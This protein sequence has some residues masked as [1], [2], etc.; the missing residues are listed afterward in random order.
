MVETYTPDNLFDFSIVTTS[1][2]V[3][4][5][6]D[7]YFSKIGLNGNIPLC[8]QTPKCLTKNGIIKNGKKMYCDL[9]YDKNSD[10]FIEWIENLEARCY[11]LISENS[12]K[13]FQSKLNISDVEKS[14]TSITSTYKSGKFKVVRALVK[15]E[16]EFRMFDDS[17]TSMDVHDITSDIIIIPVLEI[18]G[19][20]FTSKQFHVEIELKQVMILNKS[21]NNYTS[22]CLIDKNKINSYNILN[23]KEHLEEPKTPNAI[24]QIINE[25]EEPLPNNEHLLVISNLDFP[26]GVEIE[27][28]DNIK[29]IVDFVF[30][31]NEEPMVLKK[32]M[33]IYYGVYKEAR[34]KAKIAKRDAHLALIEAKNI[35]KAYMLDN[36]NTSD[37]EF[38][39]EIDNVLDIDNI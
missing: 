27:K 1:I 15:N 26:E 3:K 17:E 32:P 21:Y 22:K 37:D 34:K 14:F 25:K 13:W 7:T 19:I 29:E 2:P 23:I 11:Q 6:G 9:I 20:K 31:N 36:V 10:D 24:A 38:D 35:K 18:S 33:S 8:I 4:V 28:T 30:D 39:R 12:H 16:N 5:Q